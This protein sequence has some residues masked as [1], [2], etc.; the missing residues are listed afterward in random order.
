M[1]FRAY[2]IRAN[3]TPCYQ[4]AHFA[5]VALNLPFF[6]AKFDQEKKMDD[7]KTEPHMSFIL[8]NNNNLLQLMPVKSLNLIGHD[9]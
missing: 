6:Q 1:I 2:A 4:M 8:K 5:R 9:I 3:W 7:Y